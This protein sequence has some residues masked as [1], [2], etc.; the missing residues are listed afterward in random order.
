MNGMSLPVKH[1][2]FEQ[3]RRQGNLLHL[4]AAVLLMTHALITKDAS[5]V[6]RGSLLFIAFDILLILFVFKGI[7]YE[8]TSINIVFRI[9]EIAFFAGISFYE[10][11]EP[12]YFAGFLNL[13]LAGAFAYIF[14][15]ERTIRLEE[16]VGIHH[17]GITLP[18]LP[19]SKFLIW[20]KINHLK[21][22]YHSIEI[23]GA[24]KKVHYFELSEQLEFEELDQIHEFCRHYLGTEMQ[25][26][27]LR[28]P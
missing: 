24:D 11:Y 16:Q 21:A 19:Q 23:H 8:I 3:L 4:L 26:S 12:S 20:A 25:N 6:Y 27:L 17:T 7:I 1:P 9:F 13:I 18:G 15:C 5:W 10:F 2:S 14:Y 28:C 22:D